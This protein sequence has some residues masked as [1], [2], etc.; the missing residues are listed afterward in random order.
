MSHQ[1]GTAILAGAAAV[2]VLGASAGFLLSDGG[3]H[4]YLSDSAA[5]PITIT[6][7][8]PSSPHSEIRNNAAKET[9]TSEQPKSQGHPRPLS[10]AAT[11][12]VTAAPPAGHQNRAKH[13][14]PPTPNEPPS[15][16]QPSSSVKPPAHSKSTST[17]PSKTPTA[18]AVPTTQAKHVPSSTPSS[19]LRENHERAQPKPAASITSTAKPSAVQV[20]DQ[21]TVSGTVTNTGN[22]TFSGTVA[23]APLH[24]VKTLKTNGKTKYAQISELAPGDST[25]YSVTFTTDAPTQGSHKADKNVQ[26]L[27]A[28]R[29][30][31]DSVRNLAHKYS[32]TVTVTVT[33]PTK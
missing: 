5:F 30:K 13:R 20:G 9:T 18:A 25:D 12:H 15:S 33:E 27:S 23:V 10:R 6:M 4:A 31:T 8:G 22:T 17:S 11:S 29:D 26:F 1:R 24:N 2:G 16:S 14:K 28:V 21:I 7:T 19:S 3:T 32:N